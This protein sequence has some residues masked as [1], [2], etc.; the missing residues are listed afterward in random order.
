M[1]WVNYFSIFCLHELLLLSDH[2]ECWR[3]FVL[4]SWLLCKP[5]LNRQE[6]TVADTL[7]LR[8]CQRFQRL[9]G[10]DSVTPNMHMHCHL[11]Q[12][13][14]DFGPLT[15]FG[16]FLLKG[17]MELLEQTPT[18]NRSVEVQVMQRTFIICPFFI[19]QM[20]M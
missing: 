20:K 9:Y 1:N 12:C 2:I 7:L 16:C 4:A 14:H 5:T 15:S 6:V 11:A 18:N 17:T 19:P 8:F 13:I 10:T 3:H